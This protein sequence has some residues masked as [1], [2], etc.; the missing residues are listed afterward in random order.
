MQALG[1]ERKEWPSLMARCPFGMMKVL[2]VDDGC[3]TT[4]S[5]GMPLSHALKMV[6]MVSFILWV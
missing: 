4:G 1:A 3:L 6:T 5:T 2:E